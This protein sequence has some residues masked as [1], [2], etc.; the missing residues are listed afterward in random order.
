MFGDYE[1][2][3]HLYGLSGASGKLIYWESFQLQNFNF[4]VVIVVC[5]VQ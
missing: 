4:Q 1:L 3:C 2:L 5:G